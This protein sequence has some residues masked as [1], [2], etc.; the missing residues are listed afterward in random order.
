LSNTNPAAVVGQASELIPSSVKIFGSFALLILIIRN[1][2]KIGFEN[3]LHSLNDKLYD[4]TGFKI[5]LGKKNLGPLSKAK[6][7]FIKFLHRR[8]R[9][10]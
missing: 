10:E 9:K 2:W 7:I 4:F 5:A 1:V 6:D 8:Q 3:A